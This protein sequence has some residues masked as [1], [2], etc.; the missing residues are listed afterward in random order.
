[1]MQ[2]RTTT[3]PPASCPLPTLFVANETSDSIVAAA[4]RLQADGTVATTGSPA[5]ILFT[6]E[7]TEA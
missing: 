1:M 5:C 2:P 7:D 6:S 4:V 3:T